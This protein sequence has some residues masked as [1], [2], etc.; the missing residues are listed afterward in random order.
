MQEGGIEE[1][2]SCGPSLPTGV[3]VLLRS[4]IENPGWFAIRRDYELSIPAIQVNNLMAHING[5]PSVIR[6]IPNLVGL[7]KSKAMDKEV[8]VT[9][10]R[11]RGGRGGDFRPVG[12]ARLKPCCLPRGVIEF[13]S[14]ARQSL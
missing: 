2:Y 8:S 14:M 3:I 5:I 12:R 4:T 13:V 11:Q 1:T 9:Q 10:S 7:I 6:A